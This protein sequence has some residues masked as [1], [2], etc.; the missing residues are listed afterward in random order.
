MEPEEL[1]WKEYQRFE[2]DFLDICEYVQLAN[3]HRNVYSYKLMNLLVAIGVEFDS[4]GNALLTKWLEKQVIQDQSLVRKLTNKQTKRDFF[5]MG[6]YRETFECP[7][8]SAST[9]TVTVNRLNLILKPF[10]PAPQSGQSLQWWAAFT[11]LKHDRIANFIT[12]ATIDHVLHGLAALLLTNI[13][14]RKDR[15]TVGV[16]GLEPS[17]LFSINFLQVQ[18]RTMGVMNTTYRITAS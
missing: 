9:R 10:H 8:F 16:P 17:R 15:D 1:A 18:T 14:F 3:E 7:S 6:D 2:D 12:S 5:N 4:V 13:F 11:S